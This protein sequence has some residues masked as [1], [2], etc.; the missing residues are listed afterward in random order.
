LT[1]L[2]QKNSDSKGKPVDNTATALDT[3]AKQKPAPVKPVALEEEMPSC[4]G[5]LDATDANCVC[6]LPLPKPSDCVA[7]DPIEIEVKPEPTKVKPKPAQDT[8][9]TDTEVKPKPAQ[10]TDVDK[11]A[12]ALPASS[13]DKG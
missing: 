11:G 5:A 3:S 10:D 4:G 13:S 6:Q 12:D 1:D 7:I 9:E 2:Q 8:D